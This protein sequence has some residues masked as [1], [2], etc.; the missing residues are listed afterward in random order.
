[1]NLKGSFFSKEMQ[2]LLD[3]KIISIIS[4]IQIQNLHEI[5]WCLFFRDEDEIVGKKL[6]LMNSCK[7]YYNHIHYESTNPKLETVCMMYALAGLFCISR[8]ILLLGG[9]ASTTSFIFLL[10][11]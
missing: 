6:F 11:H 7:P 2:K 3:Y 1:M 5:E 8:S 4:K 9:F 10:H